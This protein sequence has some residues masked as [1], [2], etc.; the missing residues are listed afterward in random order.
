MPVFA[1]K[2]SRTFWN[3]SCSLPPHRDVTVI[4][5]PGSGVTAVVGAGVPPGATVAGAWLAPVPQALRINAAAIGSAKNL[6]IL[7]MCWFLLADESRAS[8][9]GRVC[10]DP[11]DRRGTRCSYSRCLT[12]PRARSR[13][14]GRS[15]GSTQS[16]PASSRRCQ[17]VAL[18]LGRFK[19]APRE[20]R[21][22]YPNGAN[23][24]GV[25]R[26]GGGTRGAHVESL[27]PPP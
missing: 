6:E 20:G 14:A 22:A 19:P 4:V 7:I 23:L 5:A 16:L 15:G 1:V 10:R 25:E 3:D 21:L 26:Q 24:P 9:S 18:V 8:G 17:P 13:V 2:A 12:V 27:T 11:I